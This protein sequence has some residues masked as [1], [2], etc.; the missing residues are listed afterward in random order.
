MKNLPRIIAAYEKMDQQE[1][2]RYVLKM[3][4]SAAKFPMKIPKPNHLRVVAN[5]SR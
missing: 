5:K 2:D 1:R 3:E 4:W